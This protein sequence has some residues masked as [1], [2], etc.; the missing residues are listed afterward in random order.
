MAIPYRQ[1]PQGN[2]YRPPQ[3]APRTDPPR[4]AAPPARRQTESAPPS[5]SAAPG[6]GRPPTRHSVEQL[7]VFQLAHQLVLRIY[8]LTRGFPREEQLGLSAELRRTAASIPANLAEGAARHGRAAY[9]EF[10]DEARSATAEIRYHMMLSRDLGYVP[11]AA[12]AE[13]DGDYD[14][15]ARMLTKLGQALKEP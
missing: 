10:V 9:R 12:H 6:A 3:T 11:P 15:V 7:E 13:I 14:R 1:R 8:D 2:P 4:T 5:N